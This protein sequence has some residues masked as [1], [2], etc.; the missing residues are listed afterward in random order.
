[1]NE[2]KKEDSNSINYPINLIKDS[3]RLEISNTYLYFSVAK[4]RIS[5]ESNEGSLN[6]YKAIIYNRILKSISMGFGLNYGTFNFQSKDISGCSL[7][8]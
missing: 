5:D 8:G 6:N 2:E 3:V 4:S 7:S 1:L